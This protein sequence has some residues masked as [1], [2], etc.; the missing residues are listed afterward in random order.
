MEFVEHMNNIL[1]STVRTTML[2]RTRAWLFKSTPSNHF[3][4]SSTYKLI[5]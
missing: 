1:Y 4:E 2:C 5:F 3:K